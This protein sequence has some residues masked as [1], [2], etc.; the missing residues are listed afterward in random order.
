MARFVTNEYKLDITPQGNY[1]VVYLSQ[2]ENGR[3]IKFIMMNRGTAFTIPSSG[4]SVS[5]SGVK[6]NGGFYE[7]TC[8][9]DSRNVYVSVV[10][11][12]TDASG[13]GVA[14]IKFTD[15]D[16]DVVVSAKFVMN[17]QETPSDSGIE[18]PT[19]AETI[20]QQIL[21][22]INTKIAELNTHIAEMD[23]NYQD[24]I[25]DAN[26]RMTQHETAV[27][28]SV[29]SME[30]KIGNTPMGTSA[31]TVT[32]AIHELRDEAYS[33]KFILKTFASQD[34]RIDANGIANIT[35]SPLSISGYR[36]VGIMSYTIES[37]GNG[38]N[39]YRYIRVL[40]FDIDK[41]SVGTVNF[42]YCNDSNSTASF[43]FTYKMLYIRT[44]LLDIVSAS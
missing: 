32:G 8:E 5:I 2:F 11:D 21:S 10:D 3:Q 24:F 28:N 36:A 7:H 33:K 44:D 14:T 35:L 18:I 38:D 16:G 25:D 27:N 29:Q 41:Q 43:L 4:I 31:T 9:F 23:D 30:N 1:P 13:R 34:R 40:G 20:L 19:V 26:D 17:V 15:S 39:S 37:A 42:S 22:E 6:S 12:M